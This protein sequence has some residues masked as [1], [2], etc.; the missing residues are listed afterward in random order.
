MTGILFLGG[1]Q[2]ICLGTIGSYVGRIFDEVR[3]RPLYFIQSIQGQ[4]QTDLHPIPFMKQEEVS[5]QY[6]TL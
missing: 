4:K 1:I 5:F 2:L 6:H 3:A